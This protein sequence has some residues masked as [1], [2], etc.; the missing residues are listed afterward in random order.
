MYLPSWIRRKKMAKL[1]AAG[2]DFAGL[3]RPPKAIHSWVHASALA[4]LVKSTSSVSAHGFPS[5]GSRN[6]LQTSQHSFGALLSAKSVRLRTRWWWK[7]MARSTIW[8]NMTNLRVTIWSLRVYHRRR[9]IAGLSTLSSQALRR[10]FS[11]LVAVM[12]VTWESMTF[13]LVD[14]TP[15]SNSKMG[16]S[17]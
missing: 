12:R 5:G 6:S 10:I 11:N 2:V 4:L 3:V 8:S 1:P 17:F 15:K 13:L 7:L 9:T 16:N 14:A